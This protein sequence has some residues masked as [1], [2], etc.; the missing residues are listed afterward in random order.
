MCGGSVSLKPHSINF[1]EGHERLSHENRI[2]A[3]LPAHRNMCTSEESHFNAVEESTKSV[4]RLAPDV[5]IV[6]VHH[7]IKMSTRLWGVTE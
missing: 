6:P 1:V 7:F 5:L 2:T 4:A 3:D